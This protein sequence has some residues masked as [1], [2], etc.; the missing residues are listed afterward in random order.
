MGLIGA[1]Y[2]L[3]G[4]RYVFDHHDLAP[5]MYDV[6]FAGR[7]PV[8]RR[9]LV[10]SERAAC[11]LADHVIVTNTSYAD[12]DASRA[13]VARGR[14]TVVRNG[15]DLKRFHPTT[16]DEQV[17]RRD[18]TTICYVGSIGHHDGLDHLLRSV[19]ILVDDFGQR[20]IHCAILGGGGALA[21]MEALSRDLGLEPWVRFHGRVPHDS[22]AGYLSAADICVAPEPANSY[23]NRS[24]MIKIT[25]YMAIGKPVVAFDLPEHRI[26]AGDGALYAAANDDREFARNL[27]LLI[28]D[29]ELR[30][31]L[32]EI[33]RRRVV[34]QL[35]W[36]YQEPALLAV[37]R[38]LFDR[39]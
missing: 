6:L 32:G 16:P 8:V 28:D 19:R 9:A 12:L 7:A 4:T 18:Q 1:F 5:E 22:V 14:I 17:R 34:E 30:R 10:L 23:N 39:A 15:P 27:A 33:G 2:R 13:G 26:S 36:S 35:A 24:T 25:E 38:G 37:Y 21:T 20:A 11:R 31:R 29:P 3:F